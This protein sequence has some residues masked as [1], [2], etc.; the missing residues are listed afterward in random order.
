MKPLWRCRKGGGWVGWSRARRL[1]AEVGAAGC[2]HH[3]FTGRSVTS[4]AGGDGTLQTARGRESTACGS[5][6][7]AAAVLCS[8]SPARQ[9]AFAAAADYKTH[10][11]GARQQRAAAAAPALSSRGP[12]TRTPSPSQRDATSS[13]HSP[14]ICQAQRPAAGMPSPPSRT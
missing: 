10:T 2:T 14:A 1:S 4:E 7:H 3:V 11:C 8:E 13:C 6:M 12:P 5:A 9:P